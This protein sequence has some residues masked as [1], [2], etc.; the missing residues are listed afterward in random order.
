MRQTLVKL[1]FGPCVSA[2]RATESVPHR[3]RCYARE[4]R[5]VR[6]QPFGAAEWQAKTARSLG[7]A[8]TFRKRDRAAKTA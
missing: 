2:G 1:F 6:G 4:A 5:E 7:L 3:I 8:H